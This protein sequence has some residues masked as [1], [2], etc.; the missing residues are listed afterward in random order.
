MPPNNVKIIL[1]KRCL[2]APTCKNALTGARKIASIRFRILIIMPS[3][4]VN[5]CGAALKQY[6]RQAGRPK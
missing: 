4:D 5:T 1:I 6:I 3:V 2:V